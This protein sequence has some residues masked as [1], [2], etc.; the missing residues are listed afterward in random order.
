MTSV[1]QAQADITTLQGDVT[2]LKAQKKK[3]LIVVCKSSK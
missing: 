1:T 3:T 2:T